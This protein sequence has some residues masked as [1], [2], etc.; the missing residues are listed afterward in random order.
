MVLLHSNCKL[1]YD[2]FFFVV[3][4][5]VLFLAKEL[6]QADFHEPCA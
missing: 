3:N 6:L 5:I 1:N 2:N 4:F